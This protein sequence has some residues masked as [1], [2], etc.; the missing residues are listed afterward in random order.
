MQLMIMKPINFPILAL[1]SVVLI[2]LLSGCADEEN[3][4]PKNNLSPAAGGV[5]TDV[6]KESFENTFTKECVQR[7]L[8]HSKNTN[9]D[10]DKLNKTCACISKHMLGD[11][12]EVEADKF[13]KERKNTQS[14]RIRYDEAAYDCLQEDQVQPAPELFSRPKS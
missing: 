14:M 4:A 12:T 13:L 8:K 10:V 3:S 9:K 1:S 6:E 5:V 2:S 7:E 11:L